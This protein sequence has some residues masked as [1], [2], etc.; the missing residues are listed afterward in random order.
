MGERLL[1]RG[2]RRWVDVVR[3]ASIMLCRNRGMR[4][5]LA[6]LALA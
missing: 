4:D 5:T 2:S 3:H 1:V 6:Q